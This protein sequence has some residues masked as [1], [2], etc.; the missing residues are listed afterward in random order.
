MRTRL[1][2]TVQKFDALQRAFDIGRAVSREID[3][4]GDFRQGFGRE[5]CFVG[6]R[7]RDRDDMTDE[8]AEG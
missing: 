6:A 2:E 1:G 8:A 3:A 7:D 4:V 5:G